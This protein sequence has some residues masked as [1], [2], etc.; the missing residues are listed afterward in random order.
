M[1]GIGGVIASSVGKS[2]ASLMK[3]VE[4]V[5]LDADEKPR[6]M[7]GEGGRVFQRWLT[8]FKHVAYDVEDMLDEL[9]VN[10]LM[11]KSKPKVKL[12]FSRNN[13][14]LQRTTMSH[15][16]KSVRKKIDEIKKEGQRDL[17]LVPLEARAQ[18]SRNDET[19]G[20]IVGDGMESGMVGR[21][22][23]KEKIIRLLLTSETNDADISIIPVVGLGGIGKI[24]LVESVLSD[25]RLAVFDMSAWV[26]VS[27]HFSLHKI[28]SAILKSLNSSINL[29]NC[30]SQFLHDSLKKELATRRYLIVL[31]D[32]WEEDG[33]KLELLKRMLQY[34][35]KGS[36]IIVTTRNLSVVQKLCTGYLANEGKICPVPESG[37]IDLDLL[38]TDT[39]GR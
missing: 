9:D 36:R 20:P 8:K 27:E 11:N 18:G 15:R 30:T 23:E 32:L 4:A 26:N 21:N 39:A 3:D 13:Q 12:W 29:D 25:K 17:S 35:C 10:E 7:E 6:R 2:L 38:S 37:Q 1:S 24:T 28:G 22:T 33:D 19:F 14:L 34:G 16:M 31:D 5:L